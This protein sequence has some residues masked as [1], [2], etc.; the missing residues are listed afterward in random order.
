M[1]NR[2]K[3]INIITLITFFLLFAANA[4]GASVTVKASSV[5]ENNNELGPQNVIDNN[6]S[7]RW[8]SDFTDD[9]WLEIDFGEE[10][11]IVGLKLYWEAAFG[12]SYEIKI[13]KDG[14]E[15]DRVYQKD[16]G[17]RKFCD[18]IYF[19]KKTARYIKVQ[20][21]ERG[22]S[23]GYS[24]WEIIVKGPDEELYVDASS[25]ADGSKRPDNIFDADLE[26]LW[27]A[28]KGG[29]AE[30]I[31]IDLRK[32]KDL[33]GIVIHWGENY[34]KRF[35]L[36]VSDD[37]KKWNTVFKGTPVSGGT[38]QVNANIV[39]KRY[40]RLVCAPGCEIR[41]IEFRDWADIAG[42]SNLDI[43]RGLT[44]WEGFKWNTFVGRDGSFGP[45]PYPFRV[46]FWVYDIEA[47]KL[48][49]P[50][51]METE[52]KLDGGSLPVNIISWRGD[53]FKAETTIFARLEK[54][55]VMVNFSSIKIR[56]ESPVPRKFLVYVN[57]RTNP[58][59]KL[60]GV[61]VKSL[62]RR[63]GN[64]IRADGKDSIFLKEKI[65]VSA[66]E[67]PEFAGYKVINSGAGLRDDNAG[68]KG[69]VV[70]KTEINAGEEKSY[71]VMVPSE[72]GAALTADEI[73]NLDFEKNLELTRTF[74]E[75]IA[76][77]KLTV[78]DKRYE[79]CF[80]SSIY[81]MLIMMNGDEI[82]P[83]PFAYKTFFLHD[84]VE[85]AGAFDK[86]GLSEVTRRALKYFTYNEGDGYLDGLG[87]SSFALFE[88]YRITKDK[89]YLRS[90]YPRILKA[91]EIIREKRKP[92][93]RPGLKDTALYGLMPPSVSQDNFSLPSHL[94]QDNWWSMIGLKAG[95]EAANVLG[96]KED[97]E[98]MKKE[99][100][101]LRECALASIE[102]VM[103]R[104]NISYMPAFADYWPPEERKV[105]PDH[106]ILGE[107]QMCSSHRTPLFPGQSLGIDVP[108]DLFARSYR[109]YWD[110]TGKFSGYDG[111]W[112]VEYEQVFWG[113]NIMIV[114]PLMYIGMEDVALKS[115]EWSI[116]NLSCPGGWM[117]AMPSVEDGQGFRRIGEGIIG[118]VPHGWV[119][120]YYVLLLRNM[121]LRE[122]NGFLLLLSCVPEKWF[123]DGK[124]IEL[125]N[126]PTYFGD[127]SLKVESF[128]KDG[129]IK[130]SFDN[131]AP[132]E[133][134]YV[135]CSPLR[136][137]IS[138]VAID[139]IPLKGV[140]TDKIPVP[141]DAREVKIYY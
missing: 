74:W 127:V 117:E 95:E 20:F 91:C 116:S 50:E 55:G 134:G 140:L 14:R 54:K 98:W 7:T 63:G 85:M 126:A 65:N 16:S 103:E 77:L 13:S 51:T 71:C 107:A 87:G 22:T 48:Y 109:H 108:E 42:K 37:K 89:E 80:Y 62:E 53:G 121:L 23:W 133:A 67:V 45:E 139:G 31:E 18:D 122:E 27:Q 43:V 102:K 32:E 33:G 93:L 130:L 57:V 36:Q 97:A 10:K 115:L 5:Q 39:G 119:A 17:I 12:K 111:G 137:K 4:A 106:R 76:P 92:N 124:V 78:P 19:G 82:Y 135:I 81:Y 96:K 83:G 88:H 136:K 129:F 73:L 90:V 40:I 56:N 72:N 49:T 6:M 141:S 114:H 104:E 110:V 1:G 101:S 29:D 59:L 11:D 60:W 75:G 132:P 128:I 100:D 138:G 64:I 44:G 28:G 79:D 99:Y 120:G 68:V 26:T 118:D 3:N 125:K 69:A 58:M 131:I 25:F 46:G 70:Y 15:W 2:L 35:E 61:L 24:L 113:Y 47:G 123:D 8:S 84:A 38:E 34:A 52:W 30:W 21:K 105:D 66:A 112:Y 41:E 9:E 94:Y 86:V